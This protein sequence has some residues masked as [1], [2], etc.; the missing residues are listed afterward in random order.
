MNFIAAMKVLIAGGAVSLNRVTYKLDEDGF[1]LINTT[2]ENVVP[3]TAAL[4]D[5][6][7]YTSVGPVIPPLGTDELYVVFNEDKARWISTSEPAKHKA[8]GK[9]VGVATFDQLI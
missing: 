2:T 9:R 7:T 1:S 4:L 3:L 8:A 5:A 6:T